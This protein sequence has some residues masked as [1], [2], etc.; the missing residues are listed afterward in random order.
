MNAKSFIPV[1]LLL[2][3]AA[4]IAQRAPLGVSMQTGRKQ[5]TS[6][7]DPLK[8]NQ[9]INEAT[10]SVVTRGIVTIVPGKSKTGCAGP[11]PFRVYL[12]R[13]GEVIQQGVSD[14]TRSVMSI[15]VATV[16]ALAKMGDDLVI[17]PTQAGHAS[18]KRIIKV[19]PVFN[20]DLF[21]FLRTP[22][23]GC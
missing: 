3:V 18:A 6:C 14:T 7:H 19:R 17:E 10:F 8:D 11:T 4:T 2:S 21:S 15:E 13:N 23:K 22:K 20:A 5:P 12:R 1:V 16:L 9:P